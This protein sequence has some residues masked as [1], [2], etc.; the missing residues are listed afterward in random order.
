MTLDWKAHTIR[1]S[2]FPVAGVSVQQLDL[3]RDVIGGLPDTE[4]SRLKEGLKRQSGPYRTGTITTSTSP[5]RI[6]LFLTPPNLLEAM[7]PDFPSGTSFSAGAYFEEFEKLYEVV[8]DWLPAC[9][10]PIQ[11]M[12]IGG[13]ALA[14]AQ[15]TEDAYAQLASQIRSLSVSPVMRDLVFR[16][17]WRRDSTLTDVG[18]LNRI[19]AWSAAAIEA[20][21]VVAGTNQ[22]HTVREMFASLDLDL[23]TPSE[24]TQAFEASQLAP[25]L[26]ELYDL[27]C[28]ILRD[29]ECPS[30]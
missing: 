24:R 28:E 15:N 1:F 7:P 17:N 13:V 16:V 10:I 30:V 25:I 14:P 26:S 22:A 3:W 20:G 2:L 9:G 27:A 12:A 23:S 19:T 11:R 6:D 29:G 8:T 5:V 21:M 18:T 4:E